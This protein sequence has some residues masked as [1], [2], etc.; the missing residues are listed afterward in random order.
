MLIMHA[1]F[2]R[3]Q[4]KIVV[5]M[6]TEIVKMLQKHVDPEIIQKL[7]KLQLWWQCADYARRFFFF[8]FFSSYTQVQYPNR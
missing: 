5:A 3:R 4:M 7:F 2:F 8:F 1:F 6:I